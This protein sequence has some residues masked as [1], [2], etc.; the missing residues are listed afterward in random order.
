MRTTL[1]IDDDILAVARCMAEARGVTLGEAVSILARRGI[2]EIGLKRSPSG[3]LVFDVPE[4][5]PPVTDEMVRKLL[6]E[7]FP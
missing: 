5:F 4:D 7:D 1:T 3:M 6:E 2:P